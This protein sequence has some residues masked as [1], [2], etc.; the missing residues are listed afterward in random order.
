M[1]SEHIHGHCFAW[2]H[3][4]PTNHSIKCGVC[5]LFIQQTHPPEIFKRLE[6]QPCARGPLPD[7]GHFGLHPSHSFYCMGAVLL[8]TKCYAV[9][10]PGQLT[11]TM[12]TRDPCEGASRAHA[13]RRSLWVQKYPRNPTFDTGPSLKEP[14]RRPPP[15]AQP[16]PR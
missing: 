12:A 5:T 10:K 3:T 13:K 14:L 15:V 4:N 8:C 2:S 1:A 9:H 16:T 11:P 7:I 6:A